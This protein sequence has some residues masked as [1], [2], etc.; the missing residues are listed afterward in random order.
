MSIAKRG[1]RNEK[2]STR[3]KPRTKLK[4]SLIDIKSMKRKVALV[5]F[6][7]HLPLANI[8]T[9][10]KLEN[11]KIIHRLNIGRPWRHPIRPRHLRVA[12]SLVVVCCHRDWHSCPRGSRSSHPSASAPSEES[13][14][15]S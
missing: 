14:S 7:F 8:N 6:H 15:K 1:S 13:K 10:A 3:M 4:F 5:V 12:A 11:G 9:A 2:E